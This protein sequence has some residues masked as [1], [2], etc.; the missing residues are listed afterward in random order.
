MKTISEDKIKKVARLAEI[1]AQRKLLDKEEGALKKEIRGYMDNQAILDA[2]DYAVI[3][4]M[5]NRK[6]LDKEAVLEDL[7]PDFFEKYTKN[8]VY[9]IMEV[10]P[11]A[12]A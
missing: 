11:K 8:I 10:K 5:R 12:I 7:G 1:I 9:E 4:S 3:V 6:D 2:G